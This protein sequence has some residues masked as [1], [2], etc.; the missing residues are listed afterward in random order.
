MSGTLYVV[1]T[2]IGN[3]EDI[4]LRALRVLREVSV[5]AAEDTRHTA[6]LLHHH[7]ISTPTISFHAHNTHRRLPEMV[8]R[9]GS[10]ASVALVS[11][12][13]TP[14]L[15]DPGLELI[16]ACI[17]RGI[18]VDPVPGASAPLAALVV[19]GFPCQPLTIL[20][21][22]PS[23]A[24]ARKRWLSELASIPHTVVFFETPHRIQAALRDASSILGNR[25]LVLG[26]ELTKVH[27]EFLRGTP[28]E[29]ANRLDSAK[30]EFTV[31]VGP[32]VQTTDATGDGLRPEQIVDEFRLM[33]ES[34]DCTRRQAIAK[35]SRKYQLPSRQIYTTL[36]NAKRPVS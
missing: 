13:G 22:A 16:Q 35:L 24:L 29:L 5:I 31:V 10:G 32:A 15:S 9:L 18:P 11:D 3:L 12:A 7:G 34:G 4:T 30:G 23:K 28:A 25:P 19:S 26:R 36:E 2:P 8:S 14:V 21:F 27:Q 6:K 33:T 17:E 1:A 20:G